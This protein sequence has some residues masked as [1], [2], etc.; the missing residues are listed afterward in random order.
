VLLSIRCLPAALPVTLVAVDEASICLS[1]S[2][3]DVWQAGLDRDVFTIYVDGQLESGQLWSVA[4]SGIGSVVT[5][6]FDDVTTNPESRCIVLTRP[7]LQGT[8]H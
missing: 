4:A 2:S 6:G 7:L 8:L 3:P 1:S 5:E